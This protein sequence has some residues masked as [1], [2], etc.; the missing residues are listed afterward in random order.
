MK[1]S[2][3]LQL[4]RETIKRLDSAELGRIAGGGAPRPTVMNTHCQSCLGRIVPDCI[5]DD[6]SVLC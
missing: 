3:K 2:R 6:C 1:K 5:S 4:D